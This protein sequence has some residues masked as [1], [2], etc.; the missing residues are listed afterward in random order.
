[1]CSF[2]QMYVST[3]SRLGLLLRWGVR[4]AL[5][6]VGQPSYVAQEVSSTSDLVNMTLKVLKLVMCYKRSTFVIPEGH[7]HENDEECYSIFFTT[8]VVHRY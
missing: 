2:A 7:T 5:Y 4:I 6:H 8:T 3:I 1:M